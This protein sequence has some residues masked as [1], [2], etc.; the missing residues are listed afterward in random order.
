MA[1]SGAG[2][3]QEARRLL[4]EMR[5]V[6]FRPDVRAYNML[7]KGHARQNDI[8]SLGDVVEDIQDAGLRPDTTTYN[9]LVDA[10]VSAGLLN[11]VLV[12][13]VAL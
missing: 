6:G 11:K 12:C 7:L 4:D 8:D 3:M 10:Y 2:K 9:T 5:E 1:C 13:H